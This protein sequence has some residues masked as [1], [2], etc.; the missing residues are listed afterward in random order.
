[1]QGKKISFEGDASSQT[2]YAKGKTTEVEL[3]G[4]YA[5]VTSE[6]TYQVRLEYRTWDDYEKEKEGL[7]KLEFVKCEDK[8]VQIVLS[9]GS[10]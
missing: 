3:T 5:M 2:T 8:K 1:M 6:V 4:R 10:M 9:H 7:G